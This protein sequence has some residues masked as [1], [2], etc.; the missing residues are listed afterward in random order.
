MLDIFWGNHD[1]TQVNRQGNDT[2]TQY[3]SAIYYT[4]DEQKKLIDVS[5]ESFQ[6]RLTEKKF[7]PIAT[8][9]RKDVPFYFAEDYHQQYL[10]KEPGGYCGLKGTGC[11]QPTDLNA[12]AHH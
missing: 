6:K 7:G 2:G 11:Y 4:T 1:P 10:S 9:I 8:E 12:L 3:R 5:K